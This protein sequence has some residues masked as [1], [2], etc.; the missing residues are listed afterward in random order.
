MKKHVLKFYL[1]TYKN[2]VPPVGPQINTS[3]DIGVGVGVCMR[4]V[5]G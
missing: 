5:H 1:Q 2:I 3:C 4:C